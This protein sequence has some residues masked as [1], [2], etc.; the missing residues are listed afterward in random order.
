MT[1]DILRTLDFERRDTGEPSMQGDVVREHSPDGSECLIVYSR[2]AAEEI[3]EVIRNEISL[4]EARRY[5]LEWKVY[6][7]DTPSNLKDRL[8]AA[9]FEPGPVESLMVLRLNEEAIAAFE[10]P[11]YEIKRIQDPERLDEVAA[12]SREIGRTNVEEE[13]TRLALTLQDTPDQMSVYVAYIDGEAVACGRIYF[14]ENSEFAELCGGR[15]KTTHRNQGLYTALVAA[16]L[17]EALD[18]NRKYIFVDALPT[19]EPILRRRG[20]QLVTQTQPFV[21]RPCS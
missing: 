5:T 9:G 11:A 15:T 21:Y 2:C 19:S 8:L 18:R 3:D 17:R 4:A 13:K 1:D 6:G 7:Y 20:F 12:V 16:R 10:A 14:K